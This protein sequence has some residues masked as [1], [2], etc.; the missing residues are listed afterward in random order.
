MS[1]SPERTSG[2]EHGVFDSIDEDAPMRT[3]HRERSL[4]RQIS[5][6]GSDGSDVGSSPSQSMRGKSVF[7]R[8]AHRKTMD[9]NRARER[10]EMN[11]WGNKHSV[12]VKI[13]ANVIDEED[14]ALKLSDDASMNQA[15]SKWNKVRNMISSKATINLL[16][17]D[18]S[19]SK[20]AMLFGKDVGS[21]AMKDPRSEPTPVG[22]WWY[23]NPDGTFRSWWDIFQVV[24]L[25]YLACAT[26][27]RVAFDHPAY[28]PAFWWEFFIDF[29]FILDVFTNFVT[30]YW[31][32]LETTSVLVS[33]P[34][35]IAVN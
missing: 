24:V 28:G 3:I 6:T 26:P 30:G 1:G 29:Y 20:E 10:Y 31:E 4:R 35:P 21:E 12:D 17:S 13:N 34:W 22:R 19:I 33:A 23:I 9:H 7:E 18:S 14:P 25:C 27:Y 11:Q 16:R 5:G 32:E 8:H 15:L 2:E